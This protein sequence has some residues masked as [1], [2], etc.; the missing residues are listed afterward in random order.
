VIVGSA[1]WTRRV[2]EKWTPNG[3]RWAAGTSRRLTSA[4]GTFVVYPAMQHS[5]GRPQNQYQ[6][7]EPER[8]FT[9]KT[10][11]RPLTVRRYLGWAGSGSSFCRIRFVKTRR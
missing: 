3:P 2:G 4:A 6:R 5:A 8:P 7:T 10:I 9:S 11:P 1:D